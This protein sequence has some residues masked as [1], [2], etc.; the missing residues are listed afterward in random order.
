MGCIHEQLHTGPTAPQLLS[1]GHGSPTG[2]LSL[3]VGLPSLDVSE[4]WCPVTRDRL[5]LVYSLGVMSAG[6]TPVVVGIRA[7]FF[8]WMND[9]PLFGQVT[10]YLSTCQLMS[11]WAVFVPW[12]LQR[13]LVKNP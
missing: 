6:F 5:C 12:L 13:A 9:T 8:L 11:I 1:P 10:F 4:N 7:P 2:L 3:S